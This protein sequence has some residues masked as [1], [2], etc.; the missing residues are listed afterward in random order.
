[1]KKLLLLSLGLLSFSM[2]AQNSNRI[3]IKLKSGVKSEKKAGLQNNTGLAKIDKI[4]NDFHFTTVQKLNS[5]KKSSAELFVITFPETTNMEAIMKAYR[6]T[7]LVEYAEPDGLGTSGGVKAVT[8]GPNDEFYSRQ[9]GL[10]NNGTFAFYPAVAGADVQMED[11]WGIEEG[12]STIVVAVMDSGLR[13]SHPEF[14]GRL[15]VNAQ[16][17]PN[18]NID[19]DNN[20]FIDDIN[21]WDFANADKNPTD[22]QGHGTN[23]AGIIAAN[24]NNT[25]GYTG[26]DKHCKVMVLKGL[27]DANQGLYSWWYD[28]IMYATDNGG[29]V[30]NLSV[31]G[32]TESETLHSAINYA[33]ENGVVVVACMMNTNNNVTY[34]PAKY[35]G[36]IAVGAT[37]PDD[38]RTSPFFWAPNSGSNYGTHL[39]VVAPGNFIYG[40]SHTSNNNYDSYWGGTSQATP[41]VTGI[42]SL[43]LAQ[44]PSRTPAEIKTLL[45][46]TAEDMVGSP[47]EDVQGFD[48]YYGHGRV[49]AYNALSST[50][51][52]EKHTKS[53]LVTVYPNPTEGLL[54]IETKNYPANVIVHNTLGQVI[55]TKE[56]DNQNA[57]IT[58]PTSGIYLISVKSGGTTTTKKIIVR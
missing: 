41:L 13:L 33:L 15:W 2:Y 54:S 46:N 1:M 58:I 4:N 44:D 3:I 28:A 11:A 19:D 39:S 35:D 22:D 43:L 57:T 56:I 7:S 36:V 49:N 34:Y 47:T 50:M 52:L 12:S 10:N 51:S 29:N 26:V 16:E 17:I 18:N 38:T 20:G 55:L 14:E 23:V 42:V 53:E 27:N 5:G 31:G 6:G 40:L 25:I 9:W 37:N 30:I 24:G 48:I 45:E 32:N 8:S 21:G